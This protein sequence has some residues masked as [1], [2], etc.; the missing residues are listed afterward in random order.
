M[1]KQFLLLLHLLI[2]WLT[3]TAQTATRDSLLQQ[4]QFAKEDTAAVKLYMA[5]GN[6]YENSEMAKS[7]YYFYKAVELSNKINYQPGAI[8]AYTSYSGH[9]YTTGAYDS[10]IF[11]NEKV[12]A[13]A[14]QVKD[15]FHIGASLFNIGTALGYLSDYE[16]ATEYC[17]EGRKMLE[18]KGSH[19]I[20]AQINDKLQ[21]LYYQRAQYDKAIEFGEKALQKAR[22]LKVPFFL[23]QTLIN[24]SINYIQKKS[25]QKAKPL[26]NE[27]L[28]IAKQLNNI[29]LEATTMLNLGQIALEEGDYE[30][31]KRNWERSLF[32]YQQ[33]ASSGGEVLALRAMAKYYLHKKDFITA[34]NFGRRSLEMAAKNNYR[35][36]HAWA[37]S[38]MA[39]ISFAAGKTEPGEQY[40]QQSTDTLIRMIN[41]LLS[42]R[43]AQLEKKYETGKKETQ[44]KQLEAERKVQLLSLRQK[45][46]MN[47]ILAGSAV[48]ILIVSILSYRAYRQKQKL[49]QQ[50]IVQ[51]EKEK[52]LTAT[53]AV[54]KG[55]EQER[56]RLARDL[57]DGLG[58]MLSGIKYSFQNMKGNLVMTPENHQAF[59]RS[60]D[61]LDSS[62]KEMRRVA[63]NMMPEALVQFG[64]DIALKDLCHDINKSGALQINYQSIG[65][66]NAVID[67]T[68]AI[69]IYRIVQELINNAMKHS[70]AKSAIV[71]VSRTTG[72]I[73][74]TVED[75]GDGFN[76]E[77][78]SQQVGMGWSNIQ[79]RINYLKGKVD[80]RSA[81]GQGTS[82]HIELNA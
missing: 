20:E 26:L 12:L 62:I 59:E 72:I 51:L 47:Y 64:L 39:N 76:T 55:E 73:S 24:L 81:P 17:L 29:E 71:Q 32:L 80:L 57:H 54:L 42:Q 22:E 65:L 8:A 60:M 5:L 52:H 9:F 61:M 16:A 41:D 70:G 27:A 31:V 50:R 49:Q 67:Q 14:R 19:D 48:I 74:I 4:L 7:K 35:A 3:A 18:G 68:T 30:T 43:S 15:S 66:E 28:S 40:F 56:T 75:D 53:E 13:I 33:L 44:I 2:T 58:G 63:H 45:N 23:A 79:S 77:R 38:L 46:A 25:T 11:Y 36:E 21:V 34:E 37:S 78:L 1:S 69:T 10:V 82:V 6:S